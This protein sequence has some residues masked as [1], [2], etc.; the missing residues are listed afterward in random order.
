MN[1]TIDHV[2]LFNDFNQNFNVFCLTDVAEEGLGISTCKLVISFDLP[3]NPKGFI[4]RR[5]RA[6]AR[7]AEMIL[8]SPNG[9]NGIKEMQ[10]LQN[11]ERLVNNC[12]GHGSIDT[13]TLALFFDNT[14]SFKINREIK[15][16]PIVV[17]A[18]ELEDRSSGDDS[19]S[20]HLLTQYCQQLPSQE[21]YN[22]KPLYLVEKVLENK[23]TVAYQCSFLL[24]IYAPP[25]VRCMI[26]TYLQLTT[27][28]T[29]TTT[30]TSINTINNKVH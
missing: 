19:S 7:K 5:E 12:S 25:S 10:Q 13:A 23:H 26:G 9:T 2:K 15:K 28:T 14:I 18:N 21:K 29:T 24:P 3:D 6:R 8:L 17:I 11:Q 30:V 22:P 4:Q 27:T 20:I 16:D 1:S